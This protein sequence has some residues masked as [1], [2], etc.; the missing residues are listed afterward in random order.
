VIAL[1][2]SHVECSRLSCRWQ[3][4]SAIANV[5]GNSDVAWVG[6]ENETTVTVSRLYLRAGEA[7][8]AIPSHDH[9]ARC[10]Q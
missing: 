2:R 6:L 8:D 4:L 10:M 7:V 9:S 1:G 5:T 3:M